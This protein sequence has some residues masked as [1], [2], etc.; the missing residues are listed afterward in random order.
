MEASV[1]LKLGKNKDCWFDF[2]VIGSPYTN[3]SYLSKDHLVYSRS[4]AAE[5]VPYYLSGGRLTLPLNSKTNLYLYI[6][7]GWQ[8]IM[9]QN[10]H[11]SFGSQ[12]EY[13]PDAKN[14]LNWN[15]YVGD[16][17]S[18]SNPNFGMRYFS[19]FYWIYDSGKK[20][21]S[22]ACAY[23]GM[24]EKG[25]AKYLWWQANYTMKYAFTKKFSL[26][27]RVEYF[28]DRSSVMLSNIT[29]IS[30]FSSFGS[31]LCF[32]VKVGEHAMFRLE[33]RAFLSEENAY[34]CNKGIPT[35]FMNWALGNITVWF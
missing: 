35:K 13:R 34:I 27:G 33:N 21:S 18:L 14:L 24:Q 11:M 6:L 12:L 29:S 23:I 7:N 15:T 4:F 20:F 3:E 2:G 17:K 8:Q 31:S 32:N 5:N 22:T 25:N 1:G 9:N 19:D 16:E 28:N 10:K 30:G 26:S